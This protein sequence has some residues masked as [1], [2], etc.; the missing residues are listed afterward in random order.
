MTQQQCPY[1]IDVSGADIHGEATALR[2]RGRAARVELPEGVKAWWV[3]DQELLKQLLTDP[4]VSRDTYQHWPAWQNGESGLAQTWSL[5]MWVSD[6]NMITAYGPDHRR[7]RKLVAKAF[8]ARRTTA[9][10]SR[11]EEICADVLDELAALDS[12]AR[13]V[14]VDLRKH[15]A[16]PVPTHVICR[17]LGVPD[18]FRDDLLQVIHTM[19][20][21]STSAEDAKANETRLYELFN[22]LVAV[23][24]RSPGEDLTSELIAV[25]D[26]DGGVGLAERELVDTVLLMFTA[27]HETT[28]NLLDHAV[29]ALLSHPDQ[30]KAL[31]AGE[32][33]WEDAIEEVLRLQAPFANL[34]MRYAVED[35]VL[36]DLTIARGEPI[37]V[38]FAAAGRDPKVH[39]ATADT[40]DVTRPTRRDHVAFG[41]GVHHCLGA[42]LA[43]LEAAIALPALFARFPGL[44][45][46]RPGEEPPPLESFISNGHRELPVLLGP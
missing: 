9:L 15:F 24:R 21:T 39:G 32:V 6:R 13:E 3:T 44:A 4:R 40:F 23:K 11:I 31:Q 16:Y 1:A 27:G 46:A 29:Y 18:S 14:P 28:V 37:V 43:R 10:R 20:A 25:R 38:S 2:A 12:Q 26:E 17:L 5:A 34:P 22:E 41:H 45:L 7:L 42:P 8:T 30:L 19:L 35:I 36:D 33:P